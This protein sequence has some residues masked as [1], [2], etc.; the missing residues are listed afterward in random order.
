M[1]KFG[2]VYVSDREKDEVRRW[3]IGE[4]GEGTLV[5]GGNGKGDQLNQFNCPHFLFV[6]DEQSLHVSDLW[7]CRVM[8][9]RKD[10]QEG[11]V[12]AGGKNGR[13][14]NLNQL[15]CPEGTIVDHDGRIYVAD[16]ANH[17]IMRWCEGDEEGEMIV[18]GSGKVNEPNQLSCPRGLSFDGEGNLYVVD[19]ENHRIQRFDFII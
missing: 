11:I 16:F 6:D 9:W 15:N 14:K 17:R 4:K 8:K 1:D 7:N 18:G 10:A 2:F 3:K 12:V 19:Y 5:A 13:G